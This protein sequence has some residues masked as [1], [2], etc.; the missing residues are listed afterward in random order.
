MK[1]LKKGSS[2]CRWTYIAFFPFNP[3]I[4]AFFSFSFA[5][6]ASFWIYL[7]SFIFYCKQIIAISLPGA[8]SIYFFTIRVPFFSPGFIP[9]I[10]SRLNMLVIPSIFHSNKKINLDFSL[11]AYWRN[12]AIP[13]LFLHFLLQFWYRVP[14]LVYSPQ[15]R[16]RLS[17]QS[18]QSSGIFH[19]SFFLCIFYISLRGTAHSL[20]Y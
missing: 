17:Q 8:N 9:P 5:T 20:R 11:L 12:H 7:Q 2:E 10:F 16:S 13:L 19:I 1:G 3:S 4:I 18:T 15:T 6:F 14:N